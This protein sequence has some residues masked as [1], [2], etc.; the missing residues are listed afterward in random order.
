MRKQYYVQPVRAEKTSKPWLAASLGISSADS[1]GIHTAITHFQIDDGRRA[2]VAFAKHV[3]GADL[4]LIC[5]EQYKPFDEVPVASWL[6]HGLG[7]PICTSI[8]FTVLDFNMQLAIP[9]L[10]RGKL[11]EQPNVIY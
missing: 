1:N 6:V 2:P 8:Q 10:S 5:V 9:G 7:A 3:E 4:H 11:Q